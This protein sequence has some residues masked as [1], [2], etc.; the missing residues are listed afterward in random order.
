MLKR[1]KYSFSARLNFHILFSLT[2]LFILAFGV[3]YHYSRRVIIKNAYEKFSNMAAKTNLRVTRLLRTVEK[4]PDN[5]GWLITGYVGQPDAIF[6]I[7]RQIVHNNPEIFGCAIAFEPGYFPEKGD[8]FAPYSYMKGDSVV[9]TQLNADYDYYEKNW[10]RLTKENNR[11]RWSRPYQ[12]FGD[13]EVI[14]STY[15]VP[16][17]DKNRGIIG[18]F[19]VDLSLNYISQLIDSDISYKNAYII[20]VNQQGNYV[21][22]RKGNDYLRDTT[23]F[24]VTAAMQD[25]SATRIARQIVSGQTGMDIFYDRHVKS[26]IFYGPVQG[27][28]WYMALIC[29]YDEIFDGLHRFNLMVIASFLL[30]LLFLY[31]V[32][33]ASVRKVTEPLKKFALSARSIASGNFNTPLPHIQTK[34]EMSEL[35]DS[36]RDMQ[37]QLTEYIRHLRE[38]TTAQ[39]KI[40]SELRIAH[41]IQMGMLPQNFSLFAEKSE[42]DLY[43]VLQP[44]RQVGGDLYD[45]FILEDDLYFAIGDVSGKGIPASLLMSFTISLLRSLSVRH[46]SPAQI[47]T[48]LNKSITERNETDMFVTFF[49]GMLNLKTGVLKYCNAGHMPPVMTYPDRSI[50]FF[51][52]HSD[53]PLGILN[54]HQYK[55]Y[56]HTFSSGSGMLLYTDGATDAENEKGEF[57]TK[58]RL[59]KVIQAN[60]ELHPR[61]FIEKIRNDIRR[62]VKAYEQS[63]DLTLLTFIY[64]QEWYDKES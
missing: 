57:Y 43:A 61:E 6:D 23:L 38:T 14:T 37:V 58:E 3:F 7:T 11:A 24:D 20:V 32:S 9:T 63:D 55:E 33:S 39:E 1:I 40:E 4:I 54:G 52:I 62:H 60:N 31:V 49:I 46:E 10:Y 50:S 45:F 19:S 44:A 56:T 18:V 53:L 47:A 2:L 5:M 41:D 12:D 35:Y 29:P 34:D 30:L 15:S 48:F 42:V 17:R 27:T 25:S 64:G 16:L 13:K 28:E 22:G 8:C 26:F 21:I 51:E 36:F 59:L